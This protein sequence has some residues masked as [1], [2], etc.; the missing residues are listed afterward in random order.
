MAQ[1]SS[2]AKTIVSSAAAFARFWGAKIGAE[3]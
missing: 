2:I 3:V 1:K